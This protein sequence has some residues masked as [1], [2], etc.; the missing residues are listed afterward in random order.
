MLKA[1]ILALAIVATP[2]FSTSHYQ[3]QPTVSPAATN[4]VLRDTMW[5]CGDAGCV[6]TRSNSRP[7]IVCAL[8]VRSVGTL[9]NFAEEGRAMSGPELEKCNVRAK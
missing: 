5:K 7:A 4:F 3:A 2:A 9:R 8:L 1:A 6:G